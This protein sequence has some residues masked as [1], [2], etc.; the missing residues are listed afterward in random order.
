MCICRLLQTPRR[1]PATR[2]SHAGADFDKRLN[3]FKPKL[4]GGGGTTCGTV[5]TGEGIVI[6]P[7]PPPGA[8]VSYVASHALSPSM[9][10][11]KSVCEC[12]R[13]LWRRCCIFGA[14]PC[15]VVSCYVV[16]CCVCVVCDHR[17]AQSEVFRRQTRQDGQDSLARR[18]PLAV[19]RMLQWAGAPSPGSDEPLLGRGSSVLVAT[20][21]LTA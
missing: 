8:A 2:C 16:S 17:G 5:V 14:C 7:P 13:F 10:L 6:G 12:V 1:V 18:P 19:A 11:P 15:R 3:V 20:R 21:V 9:P 4:D